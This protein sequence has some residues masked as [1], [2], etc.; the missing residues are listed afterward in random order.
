M[1]NEDAILILLLGTGVVCA[2]FGAT[3]TSGKNRGAVV[4]L[5]LGL[6]LGVFGV[7]IAVL[8]PHRTPPAPR[9]MVAIPSTRP[10]PS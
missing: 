2:A 3:I 6:V 10:I 1:K 5:L 4:G 8:L 7:L 9:G